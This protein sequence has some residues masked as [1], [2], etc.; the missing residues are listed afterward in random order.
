MLPYERKNAAQY[1]NVF[2]IQKGKIDNGIK[3]NEEQNVFNIKEFEIEK[4]QLT[5]YKSK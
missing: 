2:E 1:I 5:I 3:N 4:Y